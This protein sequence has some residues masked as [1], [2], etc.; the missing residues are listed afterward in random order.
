MTATT[1][2][3]ADKLRALAGELLERER[4]SRDRLLS[5]QQERLRELLAHAAEHSPYYRETLG[6]G[7]LGDQPT[8][9]KRTLVERWD[10]IVCAPGCAARRS[11]RMPPASAPTG[12]SAASTRS[13]RR[14]ERAAC[15]GCSSTTA[16]SERSRSRTRCGHSPGPERDRAS[17]RWASARRPASTCRSA[18]PNPAGRPYRHLAGI[19]GRT[20]TR[21]PSGGVTAA[22]SRLLP[23]RIGAP[24]ARIPAVRQYQIVHEGGRLEVRLVLEPG[25]PADTSE[26]VRAA[27]IG[28]LEEAGAVAPPLRVTP[29]AELEREPGAAAKLKLIVSR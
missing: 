11:R 4:S 22:R 15:A 17:E 27:V 13:S 26:R 18:E 3:R 1:T 2:S 25:C 5:Y 9:S 16:V 20:A 23:L 6:P 21:S 8:L 10:R 29:V 12:R 14:R 19:D 28:V 7:G 24:F